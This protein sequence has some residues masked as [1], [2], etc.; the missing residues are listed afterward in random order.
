VSADVDSS[1]AMQRVDVQ[2]LPFSDGSFDA[3][4]CN[5]VLEHVTDDRRALR[6]LLRVLRPGGW[7][8]L[9]V[10]RDL[11][12]EATFEDAAVATPRER[13]R[14]FGQHDHVRVYGRDYADR[15]RRA[16]FDVDEVPYG[17]RFEEDE[18][19]RFGLD[20]DEVVF[21]CTRP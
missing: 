11:T 5:H 17:R 6:E 8:V 2:A 9:Q 4:V 21:F 14:L 3:I 12:R 18:V 15:V 7:A 20:P 16:G 19:R 10:P 1:A 13:E